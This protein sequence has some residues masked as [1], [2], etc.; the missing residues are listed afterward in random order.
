MWTIY[1][2][3]LIADGRKYVGQTKLTMERRWRAHCAAARRSKGK[4]WY[5][6]NVIHK[7]GPDAFTHEVLETCETLTAANE[8]ERRWISKL[9]TREIGRGFNTMSGGYGERMDGVTN[10]WHRPEHRAKM[11]LALSDPEARALMSAASKKHNA[12][13][14]TRA[15]MSARAKAIWQ[16]LAHRAAM[17]VAIPEGNRAARAADPTIL[18]RISATNRATKAPKVA[19]RLAK[20]TWTCKVHGELQVTDC[21]AH[22]RNGKPTLYDCRAC[23][24][25]NQ[26]GADP[27]VTPPPPRWGTPECLA[28]ISEGHRQASARKRDAR[29]HFDCGACG[30][31][32]LEDCYATARSRDGLPYYRC[33]ACWRAKLKVS[34]QQRKLRRARV[35]PTTLPAWT[36]PSPASTARATG[37]A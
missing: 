4:R 11:M 24:L 9:R 16:D 33:K 28:A 23:V 37:G 5:F 26:R 35:D 36:P 22:R 8:A 31:V 12:K 30:P 7:H 20:P 6:A 34:H 13:P 1:C 15:A 10:P 32:L 14:E 19:A 29:T 25:A 17:A 3:T 2:H 18:E 27:T 21:Y